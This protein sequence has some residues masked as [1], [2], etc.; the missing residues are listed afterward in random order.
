MKYR[1]FLIINLVLIL[2]QSAI[3]QTECYTINKA[4]FSSDRFDEFA[5]VIYKNGIVFI[6]DL[7]K[8]LLKNY[9]NSSG[10]GLYKIYFV[11]SLPAGTWN[12]PKLFSKE[13]TSRL[14]DGP[15][16]FSRKG[17]NIYYSRNLT[18]EGDIKELLSIRNKLGIFDAM[19][20]DGKWGKI[21][22]LR[23][24][25]EYYNITTPSISP[26]GQRLYF[27]SD[28]PGGYG[29][30]DLYFCQWKKDFWDNPVNLGPVINTPGNESFP[31][32]NPAGELF[33][34]S[35]GHS[36]LGGKDIFFS[37]YVDSAWIE[38]VHLDA[39][40]NSAFDDFGIVF[41]ST[42][43]GGYF[44]SVRDNS[45]DIYH[46][47]IHFPQIFYC[48]EQKRDQSCFQFLDD[49]SIDIDPINLQFEWD[50]DQ[51]SKMAGLAVTHCFNGPG[52]YR[53]RQDVVEKNTGTV[54]FNKLSYDLELRQIIQPYIN[55]YDSVYAGN[56]IDLDGLKSFLPGHHFLSFNWDMGDG[57]RTKGERIIHTY[58]KQGEYTV[59]LGL[60]AR[61]DSSGIVRLVSVS[62]KLK[63]IPR[64]GRT[65]SLYSA[66]MNENGDLPEI[67]SYKNA[68]FNTHYS[69]K[70]ELSKEAV[71]QVE[72]LK[73]GTKINTEDTIYNRISKYYTIKEIFFPEDSSYS[74]IIDEEL[75]FMESYP[76]LKF[77]LSNGFDKANIRTYIHTN[78]AEKEL[79]ALKRI[80]GS[81]SDGFF[82]K[83]SYKI[84][85]SGFPILDQIVNLMKKYTAIRL[86]IAAHTDNSGSPEAD[87]LLTKNQS[88]S[89][90]N[91]IIS[92]GIQRNRLISA[93]YGDKRQIA[94]P[95]PESERKKNR[96]IEFIIVNK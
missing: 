92:R 72:L 87:L 12:T 39:P 51:G 8:N 40:I 49:A 86:V 19:F 23:F 80:Y 67:T 53:V 21:R 13:I 75:G 55:S 65:D 64:S 57:T 85:A 68:Y 46:F 45:I 44:S 56:P 5:P 9:S 30:S 35:D 14:N 26:D 60:I 69:A 10:K 6:S 90:I 78:P 34:S 63:V 11:D 24:N 94:P 4:P 1:L 93:A 43:S 73:S 2:S 25:N 89:M 71:F 48:E 81:L 37:K 29:G 54:L 36:G 52:K 61:E 32:T 50:F 42:M 59:K 41:D 95:Y 83:N 84:S 91:Y 88:Q 27:A 77:A 47:K 7:N 28:K 31:Y 82:E 22:E 33:F 76:A 20:V 96:R 62:K 38:P 3:A 18:V 66:S 17:D 58:N 79:I 70:T 15:V 74:Y 16:S